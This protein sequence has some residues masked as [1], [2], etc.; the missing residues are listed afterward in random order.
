MAPYKITSATLTTYSGRRQ[1]V[2]VKS[3]ILTDPVKVVKE[4]ILDWFCRHTNKHDPFVKID[5]KTEPVFI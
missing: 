4:R 2:E 5:V 1:T 3:E